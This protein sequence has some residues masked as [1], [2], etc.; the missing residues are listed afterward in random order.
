MS[1]MYMLDRAFVATSPTNLSRA[2]RDPITGYACKAKH[3][4]FRPRVTFN[5]LTQARPPSPLLPEFSE[6]MDLR[7]RCILSGEMW[8]SRLPESASIESKLVQRW[9][10]VCKHW[11]LIK[12]FSP[13][14]DAEMNCFP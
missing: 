3:I 8:T 4:I 12:G 5:T 1:V 11:V 2:C 13:V 7:R 10:L 14:V 9:P 6:S